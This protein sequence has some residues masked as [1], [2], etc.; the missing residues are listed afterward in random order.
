M[1]EQTPTAAQT[2]QFPITESFQSAPDNPNWKLLG[3]ARINGG[4]ELTPDQPGEAGTA[5]LDQ[6][7]SS[8]LGVTIDFDYSCGGGGPLGFGDGFSVYLIDG[9]QTTEPGA[10]GG[11]LGYSCIIEGASI[12]GVTAGYVGIGFDNYGTFSSPSAGPGGPCP[13]PNTVAV[14]GSGNLLDGFPWLTGVEVPGGFR[15]TWEEGAHIQVSVIAGR[16][17]VRRSS[18]SDPNG[19]LLIDGFDLAGRPGQI[20]MPATFKLGFAAGTGDATAAHRI[21]NLSV[22]LPAN[23]PLTMSG[24]QTVK[25][26]GRASYTIEVQNLGPNDAPDAWVEGLVPAAMRETAQVSCRGE[27]GAQCGVGQV[28][29]GLHLPLSLPRGSKAVITL[30]ATIG[31]RVEGLMTTTARLMSRTRANTAAQQ[32]G[33]VDTDVELPR[34]SIVEEKVGDWDQSWPEDAKGRVVSTD[35]TLAAND[36]RVVAWEISFSVPE[37]TRVNPTQTQWYQIVKDG[38]DGQV[39]IES[40]NDDSH[41]IDPGVPLVVSVQM[42]YA[43]QA[44]AGDGSLRNLLA[45]EI[46]RP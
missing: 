46:T 21:R 43:S 25:A 10:R 29:G 16:L 8:T 14:R 17:T 39:I 20:A 45:I 2:A 3:S 37:G 26:G 12:P 5:F 32:S 38:L 22:A 30:S 7:F 27:N 19:S 18:R 11:G 13:R 15:A 34:V 40:P 41:T 36:H 33:S 44:D 31:R 6:P 35:L 42:L 4:L 9:V 28:T 1:S 23:M 24:P